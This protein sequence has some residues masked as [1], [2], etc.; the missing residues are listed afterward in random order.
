VRENVKQR[1]AQFLFDFKLRDLKF[2]DAKRTTPAARLYEANGGDPE[3]VSRRGAVRVRRRA[4]CGGEC[5]DRTSGA[6]LVAKT[7]E[8]PR[9]PSD[10]PRLAAPAT[11]DNSH[12]IT[13]NAPC[14]V[15]TVKRGEVRR[16][17][18]IG[19]FPSRLGGMCRNPVFGGILRRER[20]RFDTVSANMLGER[21][22]RYR[23][24]PCARWCRPRQRYRL[25]WF[26]GQPM[27]KNR[28]R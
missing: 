28:R 21:V 15:I 20:P 27:D 25:R 18:K 4:W 8:T 9:L 11:G 17:G 7:T 16:S 13:A 26:A 3:M 22:L 1:E 5:R 23:A 10:S 19:Y 6:G 12:R 24:D 14:L 2:N